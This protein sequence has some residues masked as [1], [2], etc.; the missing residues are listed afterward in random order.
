M[1]DSGIGHHF[2]VRANSAAAARPSVIS[3]AANACQRLTHENSV[4]YLGAVPGRERASA[5]SGLDFGVEFFEFDA[6]VFELEVPVDAA[7]FGVGFF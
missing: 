3:I 5:L 7:L 6:G 1:A 4:R 2:P